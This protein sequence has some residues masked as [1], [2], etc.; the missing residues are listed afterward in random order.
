MPAV[1]SK[2]QQKVK[3]RFDSFES[4]DGVRFFTI[5]GQAGTGKTFIVAD[6]INCKI[7][8]YDMIFVLAPTNKATDV[9]RRKL[10]DAIPKSK[11]QL[12]VNDGKKET[13]LTCMT[14]D[15]FF[16]TKLRF[17]EETSLSDGFVPNGLKMYKKKYYVD[18][19]I[20]IA[21]IDITKL[22]E[23][24]F[25]YCKDYVLEKVRNFR[26]KK[27]L[28]F[29][30]EC[31]MISELNYKFLSNFVSN[32]KIFFVGD[33]LQLP[34]PKEKTSYIFDLVKEKKIKMTNMKE[35]KRTSDDDIT[36]IYGMTRDFVVNVT[37]RKTI[38]RKIVQTGL[39]I[40]KSEM[41]D[42]IKQDIVDNVDFVVLSYTNAV[43]NGIKSQIHHWLSDTRMQEFSYYIDTKYVMNDYYSCNLRNCQEFKIENVEYAKN[44]FTGLNGKT[45]E[46][47]KI[48]TD[49]EVWSPKK[50]D[51]TKGTFAALNWKIDE[52]YEITADQADCSSDSDDES[53]A[54]IIVL[55]QSDYKLYKEFINGEIEKVKK[56]KG[57]EFTVPVEAKLEYNAKYGFHGI[58]IDARYGLSNEV[59]EYNEEAEDN[60]ALMNHYY[61]HDPS[62]KKRYDNP[63]EGALVF[64]HEQ[65]NMC[66]KRDS[67]IFSLMYSLT[68]HKSQGSTFRKVYVNFTNIYNDMKDRWFCEQ[69]STENGIKKN[70]TE[71]TETEKAK[72]LYVASSRASHEIVFF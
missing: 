32:I 28:I 12:F 55:K 66:M 3:K 64:L 19:K 68:V 17:N 37:D 40:D 2:D 21:D 60:E 70:F 61:N 43:C 24:E 47:Y 71:Q 16:S 52:R 49:Q 15:K 44:I 38:R 18:E 48:T 72:L 22:Y 31:S 62:I 39:F 29:I 59:A 25:Y 9:I 6:I 10:M 69:I 67:E 1:L 58:E 4:K 53:K 33:K 35:I 26:D 30:D 8:E 63:K 41:E 50:N 7:D 23:D 57:T 5:S 14:V 42:S 46:G 56:A 54:T 36:N 51:D 45:Y 34:P 65:L 27:C 20:K 13:K 11:R